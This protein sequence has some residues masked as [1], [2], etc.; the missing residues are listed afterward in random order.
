MTGRV[1]T[2]DIA[3]VAADQ[4]D[5][6]QYLRISQTGCGQDGFLVGQKTAFNQLL[7]TLKDYAYPKRI[8][9]PRR[10]AAEMVYL[11][12][13]SGIQWFHSYDFGDGTG[14]QG[15]KSLKT[16]QLEAGAIFKYSVKDKTVLDIG[17]WDGYFSFEAE[18]RGARDVLATDH[19]CWSG[20]GWGTKAG[21]DYAHAKF[22]SKVRSIDLD[23]FALDSEVH[24]TFDVVLFLGV[25]Y[26]LRNPLGGLELVARMAEDMAIIET[27]VAELDNS[28]AVLR[29]YAPHELNPGDPTNVFVPNYKALEGM[30][31]LVGFRH[32][33]IAASPSPTRA[34]AHAWK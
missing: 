17:A 22:G 26:H 13:N 32:V 20:S 10:A 16:L 12:D 15:A 14:S 19:F 25:L 31:R 9:A 27:A 24:G 7:K 2:T 11:P 1:I 29:Y 6:A 5:M 33:E 4:L 18:R 3:D 21:F 28:K 30:L 23:V 8:A 34:I